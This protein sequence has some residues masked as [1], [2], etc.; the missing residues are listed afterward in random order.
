MISPKSL[1]SLAAILVLA[2]CSWNGSPD[3]APPPPGSTQSQAPEVTGNAVRAPESLISAPSAPAAGGERAQPEVSS[4]R[5][6]QDTEDCYRYAWAQVDNDI[7]IDDD[8]AS[9]RG[10]EFSQF[11]RLTGLNK[12]VDSYYYEQ[13]RGS[14][15]ENCMRSKGYAAQ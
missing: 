7:R 10:V 13:Q 14:R 9:A 2:A 6:Q 15:L 1:I 8:I 12:R 5:K 11:S 4:E 3:K